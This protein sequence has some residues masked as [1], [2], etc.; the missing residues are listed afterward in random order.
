LYQQQ[1][2]SVS[3][4]ILSIRATNAQM[5][6]LRYDSGRESKG[7][8]MEADAQLLQ[9]QT[10]LA[11]AKRDMRAAQQELNHQL[12]QDRYQAVETTGT[13]GAA[14]PDG[15]PNFDSLVDHHPLVAESKAD[16]ESAQAAVKSAQSQAFPTLTANYTR[17]FSDHTFFP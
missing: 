7:N 5:V 13:L 16:V 6:S 4:T 8:R 14:I 12:G 17:S 11:Q 2:I 15:E 1:V 10:G 9:A 3:N